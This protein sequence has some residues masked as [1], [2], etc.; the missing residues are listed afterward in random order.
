MRKHETQHEGG[1]PLSGI[2]GNSVVRVCHYLSSEES[3]EGRR[4]GILEH[5]VAFRRDGGKS[6]VGNRS[7]WS[8]DYRK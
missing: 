3:G 8:G 1:P 4:K 2:Y 6:V 7:I 5:H